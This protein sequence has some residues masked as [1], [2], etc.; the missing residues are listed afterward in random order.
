MIVPVMDVAYIRSIIRDARER[1]LDVAEVLEA[2]GL[3]LTDDRKAKVIKDAMSNMVDTIELATMNEMGIKR[4]A[5]TAQDMREGIVAF[6]RRIF[7]LN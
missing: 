4:T 3:L 6:L 7:K 1:G 2:R 5:P